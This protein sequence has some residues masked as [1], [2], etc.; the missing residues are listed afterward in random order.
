MGHYLHLGQYFNTRTD[1]KMQ[2]TWYSISAP[3]Q[4]QW[5]QRAFED[6]QCDQCST[7][8]HVKRYIAQYFNVALQ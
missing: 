3:V 7:H 6:A 1:T 8:S 4:L 5:L 2:F